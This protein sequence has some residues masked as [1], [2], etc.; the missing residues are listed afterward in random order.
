MH[1]QP[2]NSDFTDP[3]ETQASE[4]FA[5]LLEES[6]ATETSEPN[7]GDKVTG[8][9]VRIDPNET[10]VDIG[11]RSEL[12]LPTSE[13]VDADGHP[14]F[15]VGA[16]ITAYVVKHDHE[17]SLTTALDGKDLGWQMLEQAAASGT[18]VEGK[19]TATN[20]GG[21]SVDLGGKRGFCPFSQIDLRRVD[22]PDRFIGRKERFRILEMSPD[23][24]NVV[25]SRRAVLEAER[26]DQAQQTRD[27]LNVGAAFTGQVTRLVP[28]GAFVD[29]GG[30]EGLVHISQISHARVND[31]SDALSEGQEVRVKVLE[32]QNLGEGRNERISLS[33]K[34]LAQDP[35]P[36]TASSLEVGTDCEGT[37]TRLAD[38][39]A[40]VQIQPGVEGLIHI[41]ELANRRL[42]HP[43]EVVGEGDVI[44][45]R[46]LDVDLQR[47]RI[48]LS[49]KQASDYD[50]D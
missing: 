11:S 44:A 13:I 3:D 21:L 45:V 49:R 23:G 4:E 6:A 50:G 16:S 25:L 26:A 36:A 33:I 46:V 28:Y 20:K 40:F 35:W 19:I 27:N 43:R 5:Q 38:F 41:S 17:L 24:R 15:E 22:D 14:R 8:T 30:I 18:P 47:R 7:P 32:L 48:S 39:G 37:V 42:L 12:A 1:D 31:P 2:I 10:F 29:I 34:A 9:I